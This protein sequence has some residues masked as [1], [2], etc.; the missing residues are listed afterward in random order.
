MKKRFLQTPLLLTVFFA[1]SQ[2][3]AAGPPDN[4]VPQGGNNPSPYNLNSI[5]VNPNCLVGNS[6]AD[7]DINN[8][9]A[10]YMNAG[11]MFWDRG[12]SLPRYEVPKRTDNSTTS[13]HS[14]FAAAIWL[15]GIEQGTDNLIVMVQAYRQGGLRNYWPGPIQFTNNAL[16]IPT[17]TNICAAWDQHFKCNR[18]TVKEYVDL[19]ESLEGGEPSDPQIPNEIK[20]WPGRGNPFLK[21]KS[22]FSADP[23]ARASIDNNLANFFDA[24]TNGIYN[25]KK[26]D[27][28]LWAGTEKDTECEGTS[29]NINAG[30]DQVLWWVCNDVGNTKNFSSNTSP[31]PGIGMEIHYE[32]FAYA[33]T[34]ATNDMTFLRQRLFNKGTYIMEKTYLSQWAD[35]DLGNANDDYV[36]CDVLRGLGICYNGDDNDEGTQGYGVNPPSIGVDFFRGPFPDDPYDN[37][38][39][40]LNC[41]GP[42]TSP[43]P[44]TTERI[45]MSG[46]VYYNNSSDPRIGDPNKASDFYNLM[47]NIWKDGSDISFGGQ[48]TDLVSP[49]KPKATY[50][51]PNVTSGSDPYGL[52]CGNTGCTPRSCGPVWNENTS[53]NAPGDRRF[54]ANNGP[55]TLK[56]G[57]FNECTIG[58]VWAKAT[59][60]GAIGSFG[61]LLA[62]DDLAQERFDE[63]FKRNVGPNNPNIEIV[64]GDESLIFTIIPDTIVRQAGKTPLMTT[65]NYTERNRRVQTG[66]DLFYRFQGYK[67]Y[68][69]ADDRVSVQELDN[70]DRARPLQ[71]DADGDGN[72]DINGIMDIQ[73]G[74]TDILSLEYNATLDA[75]V[76]TPKVKS[77]P[78]KGIYNSFKVNKD[79]FASSGL[80]AISNFKK[81]YFAV[82]AYGF[83]NNEAAKNPYIQGVENFKIYTAIPHKANPESFGTI[84]KEPF[85]TG[86]AITRLK[87]IGNSGNEIELGEGMEQAILSNGKVGNVVYER[88][89]SPINI[90]VY[91]PKTLR[92]GKFEVKLSSRLR[93][94]TDNSNYVFQPGDEIVADGN[95]TFSTGFVLNQRVGFKPGRAII[96]RVVPVNELVNTFDLDIDLICDN[97]SISGGAG[98][99]AYEEDE[100]SSTRGDALEVRNRKTCRFV[101]VSNPSSFAQGTEYVPYDYWRLVATDGTQ[102]DTIYSQKPISAVTEQLIPRYGISVRL[103][104]GLNPGTDPDNLLSKNGVLGSE[105]VYHPNPLLK[106]LDAAD[107]SNYRWLRS[108]PFAFEPGY[109][110][111]DPRRGFSGFGDNAWFPYVMTTSSLEENCGPQVASSIDPKF[112]SH[113]NV[114]D[115][116]TLQAM[117]RS[118]NVDIVFTSDKSKWTRCLVI[119]VDTLGATGSTR[120]RFRLHKSRR[121]SVNIDHVVDPSLTSPYNG[122]PSKGVSWFPGY[123]IDLDRGVRL[124][125]MFSESQLIDSARGNDLKYEPFINPSTGISDGSKNFIYVM[126]SPYDMARSTERALD[127]LYSVNASANLA[128]YL[129]RHRNW[130]L[131][132]VMYV[133]LMNRAISLID[134]TPQ[135]LYMSDFRVKLRVERSF[136]S[137][138]TD[139]PSCNDNNPTYAFEITEGGAIRNDIATGK[140]ALDLIRVVPNPYLAISAYENS[141][142]DNRVKIVN[143]PSQCVI[144][145][146]NLSGTLI[147]Q[148]NFDQ[149]SSRPYASNANGVAV[150]NSRGANYQTFLD[151]DMKNQNGIPIASGVYLIHIKSDKLGERTLKWFGVLRPIDLDSFN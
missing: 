94:S 45:V 136:Q 51:F 55:F 71:G 15:G 82:I 59:S 58:I 142:I 144:S 35:P 29:I 66:N 133:G 77:S 131:Q 123:A 49:T 20:Y 25:P 75:F 151:W 130:C 67:L 62:A 137:Y 72:A 113:F 65:E 32:A 9:R 100:I 91:N 143:L 60:G 79:A 129:S 74:I 70:P 30:A 22:E 125:M 95:L 31:I 80:G 42:Q 127:S 114:K 87:G 64:E 110:S 2:V 99:F 88:G 73:D 86:F 26:G 17:K 48:G 132:N 134:R 148:F 98:S 16:P 23:D 24:D 107:G 61:K 116:N 40:N 47:R 27:Y 115:P 89:K 128:N 19:L 118:A 41:R 7:L 12:A 69:L 119:Q 147:R 54:L 11:D 101:L 121:P 120:T 34:D 46:F 111:L 81:Y 108:D 18:R 96:R 141:Q 52:A 76:N 6:Q 13:K 38:D 4:R 53:N 149:S 102:R 138:S 126:N 97:D 145:I 83:H 124:N 117:T 3:Q 1:I 146:F 150:Q 68:Q 44:D 90:K 78:D 109:Y 37:I 28:P 112:D 43:T 39:W 106:W 57:D 139:G 105:I 56:P 140:S 33:S 21:Q 84:A 63:C 92:S 104:K 50:M 36:G 8:V 10:R 93:Y 85:G 122:L 5:T 14:M 135:P 103:K